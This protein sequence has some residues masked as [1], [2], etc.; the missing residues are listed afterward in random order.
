MT[1]KNTALDEVSRGIPASEGMT[2]KDKQEARASLMSKVNTRIAEVTQRVTHI[3]RAVIGLDANGNKL[4]AGGLPELI[5]ENPL[6]QAT[7]V[8]AGFNDVV[9]DLEKAVAELKQRLAYAKEVAMP[10]RMDDEECKTFNTEDWRVTRLAKVF[11]SIPGDKREGAYAWLRENGYEGMIQETVNSSSLSAA[12]KE[13]IE[14]GE[15]L[16]EDLFSIHTKDSISI[17]RK[18]K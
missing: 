3:S 7:D 2:D 9:C 12:A 8:V 1:G 10:A 18:K 11:A 15:E 6:G 5:A 14:R 13:L 16:P 4:D 17:T